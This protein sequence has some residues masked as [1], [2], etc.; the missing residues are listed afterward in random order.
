[1]AATDAPALGSTDAIDIDKCIVKLWDAELV[2]GTPGFRLGRQLT[3]TYVLIVLIGGEGTLAREGKKSRM[4][5]DTVYVCPPDTT[6]GMVA[7]HGDEFAVVLLRISLFQESSHSRHVQQEVILQEWLTAGAEIA[8]GPSGKLSDWCRAIIEQGASADPLQ[9]WRAQLGVQEL[10]YETMA[11]ARQQPQASTGSPLERAKA[12]MEEQ[13][14]KDVTIQHLAEI[15]ELSP[16]YF[17]DLFKKTYGVSALDHLTEVRMANAKRLMLRSER[18]LKDIAHE[19]GYD[20]EFYFSRKFK[21]EHGISPT[22]FMRRR[23]RRIAA[24]GSVSV[25]GYLLP[26]QLIP[27][28]APLHPKWAGYYYDRYG[29]DIPYHLDAYRNNQHKQANLERLAE[30]KP[31]LIVCPPDLEPWEKERLAAITQVLELPSAGDAGWKTALRALAGQLGEESEAE[32]WIAA[33][34]HQCVS[35]R[36]RM[37]GSQKEEIVVPV[38]LLKNRL[39]AYCNQGISDVIYGDLGVQRP[40][41]EPASGL[42]NHPLTLEQLGAYGPVRILLFICRETETLEGWK[43]LRQTPEW[44]S[45]PVVQEDKLTIVDSDPWREYSPVALERILDEAGRLF[46][47]NRP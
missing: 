2:S 23:Q 13:Y 33:Y 44:L 37:S 22:Q 19:V 11:A 8:V 15:A 43:R 41:G 9:R 25:L 34:E 14:H 35:V 24:Y 21:K 39:F 6:F 16:K 1:M 26:L 36:E 40:P 7:D 10:L 28:A 31:D 27:Y 46:S 18:K 5:P 45:L 47:G 4:R 3:A 12:Y 17:V 32:R 42:F 20:D 29:A 38:R 30:A